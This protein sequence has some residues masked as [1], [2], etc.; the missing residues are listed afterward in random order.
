MQWWKRHAAVSTVVSVTGTAAGPAAGPA[1]GA[2]AGPDAA[3]ATGT[4]DLKPLA[5]KPLAAV[6]G[7]TVGLLLATSGRYGYHRDEL[8]FR[9]AGAHP[10]FGYVDQPPLVPLLGR[11]STLLF[12]DNLPA[13]RV[14]A[15]VLTVLT[16]IFAVLAA[17]ELGG[18][19][20][21]QVLTAAGAAAGPYLLASGHILH[22]VTFDMTVWVAIC[23]LVLRALRT[24][25]DRWW[26][27]IG[28][29]AGVGLLAKHLVVLLG[30]ALLVGLVLAGPRRVLRSGWLWAGLG[31][32]A[33]IAAPNL[34]WQAVHGWPQFAMAGQ[35]SAA[36]GTLNR[37]MFAPYQILLQG[38]LLAPVWIAGLIG[39]L[40]RPA[41]R[42]FRALGLAYPIASLVVLVTGGQYYYS[43]SLIPVLLAA[44]FV[45]AEQWWAPAPSRRTLLITAV[46]VQLPVAILFALPLV[47]ADRV[48]STPMAALNETIGEQIGW[49]E[50]ATQVAGVYRT[51][52]EA[53]RS[54]AAILTTEFAVAAAIDRHGPARGLPR[55]YSGHN[56]YH[57]WGRPT[58]QT[59]VVITIGM[60]PTQAGR[61]FATCTPHG[62]VDN[63]LGVENRTQGQPILVC[64]EPR[65]P[66]PSL[67]P[68]LRD[69][70]TQI[71]DH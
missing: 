7:A 38:P 37:L 39:L 14:P 43:I 58:D 65:E 32:A 28:A 20:A 44:G 9:V 67:W 36:E 45:L 30:L 13:Q 25:D 8:Y 56:S 69:T 54:N 16:L 62:Q 64:R 19:G 50:L 15:I 26:L 11:A 3:T 68:R 24:Q 60:T 23:W 21:A 12:G 47:P 57:G 61:W 71:N 41:W 59:S 70:S 33:L 48:G 55:A 17:R 53:E 40:R 6:I 4:A 18:G 34:W 46:A 27:P 52:P 35:I 22:T 29:V 1:T 63:G 31:L 2:A 49:P 51:V 5:W 66:W 42:R 10:D